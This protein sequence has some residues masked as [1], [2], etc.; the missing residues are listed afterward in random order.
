LSAD[1]LRVPRS[2]IHRALTRR[3]ELLSMTFSPESSDSDLPMRTVADLELR[4]VVCVPLV[5]LGAF[6]SDQTAELSPDAE[7]AGLLYLD[8][9]AGEADLS[10]GNRELLQT[11]ALEASTILENARLLEGERSRQRMEEELRIARVIQESLLPRKLP[12]TGWLRAA[13]HSV[14]CHQVGGDYFD[15]NPIG[16]STWVL[17]NADVSGK[18]VSSALLASLIQGV[19]LASSHAG[20]PLERAMARLN[21]F[22][23]ERTEGEKYA[24]IFYA[25]LES[26]GILRYVN[27]GH[28]PPL[29]VRAG[30]GIQQLDATGLPAGMLEEAEY[31]A[32]DVTLLPG[33][34]LV[35]YTDGLTE[36]EDPDGIPF[37]EG[38]LLEVVRA[39]A[40]GGCRALHAALEQAVTR[41]AQGTVQKDDMTLM[42]VEY[43]PEEH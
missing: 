15:L 17:I 43:S 10:S 7:T 41:F 38:G 22:F 2:L 32:R 21:R 26:S 31:E 18:G 13:G 28:C 25:T 1:D 27:A 34:M 36:A 8:S 19:F 4:S 12:E 39:N 29:L 37:G 42:V 9:R 16:A 20:V 30:G 14:P 33:D 5:R 40:D 23:L 35:L 3:R 11:L 24:T 6:V